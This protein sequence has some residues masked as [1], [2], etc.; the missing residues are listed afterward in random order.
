[1]TRKLKDASIVT[2]QRVKGRKASDARYQLDYHIAKAVLSKFDNVNGNKS[3]LDISKKLTATTLRVSYLPTC[4]DL[5]SS[6]SLAGPALRKIR[7]TEQQKNRK[8]AAIRAR[9]EVVIQAESGVVGEHA[10]RLG[11]VMWVHVDN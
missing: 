2:D 1:M 4:K 6:S 10:H 9:H 11:S 7:R 8:P 3:V 5:H